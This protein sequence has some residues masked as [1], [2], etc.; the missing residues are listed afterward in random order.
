[1]LAGMRHFTSLLPGL[2]CGFA[3]SAVLL[4]G[5]R[6]VGADPQTQPADTKKPAE[7]KKVPVGKKGVTLVIEG[8]KRTVHVDAVVCLREGPLE[9]L[10]TRK[11]TKEHE[12]ILAADVDA[13]DIHQA[14]ILAKAEPGST[15]KFDPKFT[16]PTGTTIKVFVQWEEKG[17]VR[18]EPAQKWIL[19]PMT[20]K[21]LAVD[22]VFA[23]S[24]LVKGEE[25]KPPLY[26][27]NGGDI[28]CVSNFDT[29]LLDVPI[30]SSAKDDE[31]NFVANTDRIPPK[32]TK[33]T[34][35]L[36]PVLDKKDA[37]STERKDEKKKDDK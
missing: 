8:D 30:P 3:A 23:G 2:L 26:V 29:A 28:I 35:I 12:A 20:K 37:K 13:R 22:W 24:R 11:E 32:D 17:K 15:V 34:V 6:G 5:A 16:P 33:V 18:K 25:G 31:R 21:D 1:M 19:N 4:G 27:A 14:L 10:L 36:E 7:A 9:Q